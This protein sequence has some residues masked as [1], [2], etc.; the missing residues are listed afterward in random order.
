LL[1][2]YD[3]EHDIYGFIL[4]SLTSFFFTPGLVRALQLRGCRVMVFGDR[5]SDPHVLHQCLDCGV[6]F[7]LLDRPDIYTALISGT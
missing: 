1:D 7:I 2:Y 6:D 3:F 4:L 5:L